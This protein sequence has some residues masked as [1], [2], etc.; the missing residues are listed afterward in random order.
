MHQLS[1]Q[2]KINVKINFEINV[3]D[4]TNNKYKN[5]IVHT[6]IRSR[7]AANPLKYSVITGN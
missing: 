3:V 2:L 5:K 6:K 7:H 4:M 1:N